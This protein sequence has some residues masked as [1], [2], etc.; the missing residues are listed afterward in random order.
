MPIYW[1]RSGGGL[2]E[3]DFDTKVEDE[4]YVTP[5]P[6]MNGNDEEERM[7]DLEVKTILTSKLQMK[8]KSLDDNYISEEL[9]RHFEM[10]YEYIMK[11]L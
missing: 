3:E 11:S 9:V 4:D 7:E 8:D 2:Q 5:K 6:H 10:D 1:E